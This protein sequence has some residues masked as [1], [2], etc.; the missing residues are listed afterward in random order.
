MGL[1]RSCDQLRREHRLIGQVVHGLDGLTERRRDGREVPALPVT[2]A[3]DF[4]A[5]FVARCHE[6]KEDEALFPALAACGVDDGGLDDGG[7]MDALRADH[8][9]GERLLGAL[10]PLSSRQR[11]DGEAWSMLEAYLALLRRHIASEDG[12]LLPLAERLLSPEDDA[13]LERAFMQIEQSALGRA[14]SDALLALAG[15]V[16]EASEA[17]AAEA[18]AARA[19]L[20]ARQVM[21]PR[22][23]T[24]APED[25]LARAAELME[26]LRTRELP[27]VTG[28]AVVGILARSDM[29][30]HRGH[31]EWTAVRA[32]MTADPV[33]VAPETPIAAV[34]RLL[35]GRGFNAVPV[36]ESGQLLGMI[37]RSDLLR[38]LGGPDPSR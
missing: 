38:A 1:L 28:R 19:E 33:T 31:Y 27:V 25:S 20:V 13:A 9:E 12:R 18:P 36:A 32:A 23:R 17:V 2:G 24:V 3:V 11:F 16:V 15:A 29:E 35:L 21:R 8:R 4:F 7:L 37:A 26:S 22:P 34:A 30:P 6:A 14:G 10:R 5:G